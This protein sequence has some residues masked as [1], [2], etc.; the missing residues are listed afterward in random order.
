MKRDYRIGMRY[1]K[2]ALAVTLCILIA[3]GLHAEYP[4]FSAIAAIITMESTV[5]AGFIAGRNRILGTFVG[6]AIGLLFVI[7][8]PEN[9]FLSGFGVMLIIYICHHMGWHQ[10]ISIATMVFL[11]IMLN[12]QGHDP[13][14]YSIN[15]IEDTL[16]GIIVALGVNVLVF[17]PD[18]ARILIDNERRL[19]TDIRE[20]V[21]DRLCRGQQVDLDGMLA[22]IVALEG[23]RN[24]HDSEFRL[25]RAQDA[26]QV[27]AVKDKLVI[28]RN[29][30]AHMKMLMRLGGEPCMDE[31][32]V[33]RIQAFFAIPVPAGCRVD[34]DL[35]R[36][37]NYHVGKILD[38]L[39]QI[40]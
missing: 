11:A 6:A 5:A 21:A 26:E 39:E 9:P 10:T 22:A 4:F 14:L 2:T 34:D 19:N 27:E 24:Q 38:D 29:L 3:E 31:Q 40:G 32:S 8:M 15:R 23:Q 30:Y 33:N 1:I 37:Y 12:L 13:V 20:A 16:L 28:Y 36:V 35:N 7:L 18:T 17:P 25:K